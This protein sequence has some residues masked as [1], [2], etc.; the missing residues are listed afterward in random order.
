MASAK[1]E[2]RWVAVTAEATVLVEVNRV[3]AR[4]EEVGSVEA[5]WCR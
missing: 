5:R 2:A 1:G 3:V 4:A